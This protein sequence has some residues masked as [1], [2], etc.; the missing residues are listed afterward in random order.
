MLETTRKSSTSWFIA[1]FFPSISVGHLGVCG[2]AHLPLVDLYS[3]KFRAGSDRTRQISR[4]SPEGRNPVKLQTTS[5]PVPPFS[6]PR[7][8]VRRR[9]ESDRV[10]GLSVAIGNYPQCGE[11]AD[12]AP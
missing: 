5:P 2:V 8:T 1:S 3:F 12:P 10:P 6:E 9:V 7:P 11:P 4:R